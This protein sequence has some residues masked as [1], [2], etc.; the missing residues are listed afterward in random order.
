LEHLLNVAACAAE[1]LELEP[2][3]VR[4]QMAADLGLSREQGLPWVL[5]L[6]A[7]H[8]LDKASPAFQVKWPEG[9]AEVDARLDF[10]ELL[11]E[12]Y[13]PHGVV[14]ESCL[15]DFLSGQLGWPLR[16]AQQLG[17]A[18]GCHHGF[19]VDGLGRENLS[20]M[21]VGRGGWE[22]VRRELCRLVCR[23]VGAEYAAVPTVSELSAPAFMR[24][25][26]LTSFAD[27]LGSSFPL[28]TQTDFSAYA[29]PAAYFARA[30]AQA[31]RVLRE[32]VHWPQ[33]STLHPH[34]PAL[35][36][37]FG[38]LTE[39]DFRPR[40][41]QTALA[42]ALAQVSGPALVLVEAPMGEGKT[43]AALYAYLQLQHAA[44]HRGLYVAP[45]TQ[46]T[47]SAM[48]GR[49][50]EFLRAQGSAKPVSIQLA[51]GGTLLNDEFQ[52]RMANT[53]LLYRTNTDAE[54]ADSVAAVR[55][56]EWFTPRKRALLD[57]FGV[58]T[59]DQALLG[60]LGVSHQFVRLWGLGNRVVV[61][62][63]VHA[64]DTYTSEL[65]AA[66]VAWLRALG[67]SVV[68]MSATLPDESRRRL[69]AAWGAADIPAAATYPRWTV[70]T[71][72]V[73]TQAGAVTS[74]T[75]PPTDAAG[76]HSRPTQRIDLRPL[77]SG[78]EAVARQAVGLTVN[79]GCAAVIVNTVQR[80][81]QVQREVVRL[82]R[83]QGI[84]AQTCTRG[85]PKGAEKLGVLLYHARYPD[86]E[87]Q[88]RE[89]AVLK[90]LGK[91][92]LRPERLI[93]IATQVAEQSL[94]FDAD[95]MISDLAPVDL[96][97]QRAGRL[98]R[99]ARPPGSRR[100]HTEPALYVSGLDE[101]P[102]EAM[103]SEAWGR[104]YAPALLYRTWRTLQGRASLTLPD[105]L[106]PLVQEVYG[107]ACVAEDLC[108][109]RREAVE[110]A[111]AQL[112]SVR[113][114]LESR[115][116]SAHIG[117]PDEFWS[118]RLHRHPEEPD[119]ESVN[120]DALAAEDDFPRTRLGDKSVRIVPVMQRADGVWVV[121]P[122]PRA[123]QPKDEPWTE[124][125]TQH[126]TLQ[127]G[128]AETAKRIYRRSLGVSRW[129][130][131]AAAER[132]EL[133]PHGLGSGHRGWQAHPLLR[134]VQ[135]LDLSA[136]HRDF[137][138]VRVRLDPELGLVYESLP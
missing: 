124:L 95:V 22:K 56:E 73:A 11:R 96:L 23:A 132:G 24:L 13:T 116:R 61:L 28:P 68:I 30:R 60:V 130:L 85:A 51:H 58:G 62:D 84:A 5:A 101:W 53:Q 43:E 54:S 98:H 100:G 111:E 12:P 7:L 78:A 106:D 131:V 27:W 117:L 135:P 47:G 8:D 15:P 18:V 75:V 110:Q 91:G 42:G 104:V 77:A 83:E 137:G 19:R 20:D 59:V 72:M 37:A 113:E 66:L 41:L 90:Y 89:K 123:M 74:G 67:S 45:P 70:A 115:G 63:E 46:A 128:D 14:S 99:H 88:H 57:E 122:P 3:Q 120:D 112:R 118:T 49:L 80:A 48:F 136:G 107:S 31:R 6:I 39:G 76:N 81:Q 94:D 29:D 34:L 134:G 50:V 44:Q 69:L 17:D 108:A 126:Q 93:L 64:Y 1:I 125:V 10:S 4:T 138:T 2:P 71:Q 102:A 35:E 26:G 9:K 32:Q 33:F 87:R 40:P 92:G 36:E 65:I 52:E 109:E 21:Q 129:E 121:C 103:R 79:G 82:L 105:E 119:T 114:G 86:D 55:V 38:Y 97:L 133:W 127:K 16:L 25:A